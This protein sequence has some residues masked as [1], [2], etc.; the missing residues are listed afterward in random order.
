MKLAHKLFVSYIV[1]V[2]VGLV[3]LSIATAYVAPANFSQQMTHMRGNRF[4][5]AGQAHG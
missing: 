3:V 2:I 5:M 1:V 4:D